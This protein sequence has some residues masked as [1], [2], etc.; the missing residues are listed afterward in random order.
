MTGLV[1]FLHFGL[2]GLLRLGWQRRGVPVTPIMQAPL[3]ARSLADFWGARW[4]TA[5]SRLA[6][7]F[8]VC[9]LSPWLGVAWTVML[10]YFVSG[11]VHEVV[12]SVPAGA[13][14]GLPTAYFLLQ[15]AATLFER[16][17]FGRRLGLGRG[18]RGRLFTLGT[19]A[20]PAFW[21][22]HPAFVENVFLPMLRSLRG[23]E[24]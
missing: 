2:F 9:P 7:K 4:N 12:I 19:V 18:L 13:G 6:R 11:L 10:V 8:I 5:F 3:L 1:L 14:F 24:P 23:L 15:G 20:G 21:L 17:S 22:F 16:S